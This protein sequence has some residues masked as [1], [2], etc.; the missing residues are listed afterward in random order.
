MD[1][2]RYTSV[3]RM[4]QYILA[5]PLQ[6]CCWRL[7]LKYIS[8]LT[9][10]KFHY[11]HHSIQR[12]VCLKRLKPPVGQKTTFHCT[13]KSHFILNRE[14]SN[15]K[16]SSGQ[17]VTLVDSITRIIRTNFMSCGCSSF[18]DFTVIESHCQTVS[19]FKTTFWLLSFSWNLTIQ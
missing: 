17:Q 12:P 11:A 10:V 5:M 19:C 14:N 13:V 4:L 9:T 6:R 16:R 3:Y 18:R 2:L 15:P 7:E 8:K 1:R